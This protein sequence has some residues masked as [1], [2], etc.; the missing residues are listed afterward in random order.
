MNNIDT[1]QIRVN[2]RNLE[3]RKDTSQRTFYN[4]NI[5]K[6]IIKRKLTTQN[7]IK[8]LNSE[9][10]KKIKDNIAL[11][12]FNNNGNTLNSLLSKNIY[13]EILLEDNSLSKNEKM[14]TIEAYG[15]HNYLGRVLNNNIN[16]SEDKFEED[17]GN[18]YYEKSKTNI[19]TI[20]NNRYTDEKRYY[21]PF[22]LKNDETNVKEKKIDEVIINYLKDKNEDIEFQSEIKEGQKSTSYL[23]K[24]KKKIKKINSYENGEKM[25]L[26]EGKKNLKIN[27]TYNYYNNNYYKSQGFINNEIYYQIEKENDENKYM[28]LLNNYR[29]KVI[30]QFISY[31]RPYYFSFVKKHFNVFI[32]KLKNI[33]NQKVINKNKIRK[34][35]NIKMNDKKE[36]DIRKGIKLVYLNYSKNLPNKRYSTEISNS[37][38]NYISSYNT[39]KNKINKN[40]SNLKR[41][42][43]YFLINNT[44]INF[45]TINKSTNDIELYRNNFQ[46]EKKYTQILQ[47][48]NRKKYAIKDNNSFIYSNLHKRIGNK[49][50]DLSSY[51]K[52]I[53]SKIDFEKEKKI[54]SGV[55]HKTDILSSYNSIS[56]EEISKETI[57]IDKIN[58][59]KTRLFKE[60]Q[61]EK[62]KNLKNNILK[63]KLIEKLNNSKKSRT[64]ITEVKNNDIKKNYYL[65]NNIIKVKKKIT[66]L[67]KKKIE[68]ENIN[69][70]NKNNKKFINKI[71]KDIYTK[72]NRINIRINYVLFI[73]NANEQK[74][75]EKNI[76]EINEPLKI[77]QNYS[78]TYIGI[79]TKNKSII[80]SKKKY[81]KLSSIKEEEEKSKF[82]FSLQ[83]QKN[84]DEYYSNLDNL[85]KEINDYIN[86]KMKKK[87]I[88]KLK[89]INLF[90]CSK[91]VIKKKIFNKINLIKE[92]N[93]EKEEN[94]LIGSNQ[95]HNDINGIFLVDDKIIMN[96]NNMN[97]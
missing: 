35:I 41:K 83:N 24:Y 94:D 17:I 12:I 49:T 3:I 90:I 52:F 30:N 14:R 61:K 9:I 43:N 50:I 81:Q 40:V 91:N 92:V 2:K 73:P 70:S 54:I 21:S 85:I 6:T 86:L 80:Y 13:N 84:I 56:N 8:T 64:V 37:N 88:Y 38:D 25:N 28:M 78:F 47:R 11:D 19:N 55:P 18:V 20:E 72:D 75:S 39:K 57:K 76:K 16:N 26:K 65:K 45:K 93:E 79:K 1:P 44:N 4:S 29:K 51:N 48:K 10:S 59:S 22:K 15:D 68:I 74:N 34:N 69:N 66:V 27:E 33:R 77:E 58:N 62:D 36:N 97:E 7:T 96:M 46:L 53:H 63:K 31:F 32:S 42:S 87:L 5:I 67:K 60:R 95:K 71:M 89:V 23:N 82:S